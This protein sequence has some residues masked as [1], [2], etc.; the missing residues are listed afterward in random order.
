VR[1]I[2]IGGRSLLLAL[3]LSA[4]LL[5]LGQEAGSGADTST[6]T[7]N[8]PPAS[9][10]P[11]VGAPA[12]VLPDA[13]LPG[14]VVPMPGLGGP[15]ATGLTALP[16]AYTNY[17]VSAGLG[18]S[19]NVNLS[20]THPKAQTLAAANLFFD[21][22]RSGSRLDL[23]AIGNFSD[24]DYLEGAYSN[25]VLGRFDG[26]ANVTLLEHHL[27]WL[28]RDDY[29]DSQIDVLQSLT[30][31]NLQR[32]NVFSTG[33]D[34]TLEPTLSTFVEVQG[35]YSRNTWEDSPFSGNTETGT[36]TV[37]DQ[38]SP[39]ASLSLVAEVQQQRFDD[40]SVNT[41]YQVHEYYGHYAARA[42]RTRLD[43]QAG[44]AQANDSGS[45]T[46]S[47]LVRLSVSRNVSPFSTLSLAGGRDFSNA[48]GSFA[49]LAGGVTSG[50]PVGAGTQTAGNAVHTYGNLTWG[51]RRL[52][53]SVNLIGGW[54]R[55]DYDVQS[56]FNFALTD[57][58]LTVRREL[59][60]QL[61]AN[62]TAT[63]DRAQYDNQGFT[64][65]YGTAG[66]GVIYRPGTWVVI[67]GRYDHQFRNS[68]GLARDLGY[69]ENR[70]FVMVGYYPHSSGTGLPQQM[71]GGGFR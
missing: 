33:P 40:S 19:D 24:T 68:S 12:A 1:I 11:A 63:L 23:T 17:G 31:L 47:P 58:G 34:L 7:S 50:I 49:S 37:G 2:R 51:Y 55:R 22:I 28:V 25:Q 15:G 71:G 10:A 54:E 45:W 42:A 46:S 3:A 39:A 38:L 56:K 6:P 4:P 48:A 9:S 65:N 60:P 43:L 21:L 35:L 32:I 36:A 57:I 70:I 59:T 16:A 61:S 52:R 26:L 8:V 5:C 14:A 64:N 44:V 13:S 41:D 62:I 30:P 67:Y 69:D 27:K 53:T 18:E 20:P 66:A 29:G